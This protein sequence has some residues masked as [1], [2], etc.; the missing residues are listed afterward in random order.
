MP[1][2]NIKKLTGLTA[3]EAKKRLKKYDKSRSNITLKSILMLM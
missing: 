3:A 2:E 1:K